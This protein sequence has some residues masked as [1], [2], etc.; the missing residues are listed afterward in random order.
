MSSSSFPSSSSSSPSSPFLIITSLIF[1]QAD[2]ILNGVAERRRT[3]G[4]DCSLALSFVE[5]FGQDVSDLLSDKSIGVNK[6]QMK[7]MGHR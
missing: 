5:V 2:F 3:P 7:R 6:S 1:L 4:F